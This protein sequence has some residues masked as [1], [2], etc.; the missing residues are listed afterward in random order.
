MQYK[1]QERMSDYAQLLHHFLTTYLI[2]DLQRHWKL[3]VDASKILSLGSSECF[4][5]RKDNFIYIK[6]WDAVIAINQFQ[7]LNNSDS[8]HHSNIQLLVCWLF[9]MISETWDLAKLYSDCIW[10]SLF[11]AC[12]NLNMHATVRVVMKFMENNS[13]TS[14]HHTTRSYQWDP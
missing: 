12:R 13:S 11:E 7:I 8:D 2:L 6:I 5:Y 4:T 9:S 14:L 1:L 10:T 3:G